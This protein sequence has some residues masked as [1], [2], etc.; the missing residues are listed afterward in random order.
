MKEGLKDRI[1]GEALFE[2]VF[3]Y[4]MQVDLSFG[5]NTNNLAISMSA[6]ANLPYSQSMFLLGKM[7]FFC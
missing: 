4:F 5:T 2:L 7:L 6:N 1:F 3:V